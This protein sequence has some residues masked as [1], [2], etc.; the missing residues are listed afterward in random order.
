MLVSLVGRLDIYDQFFRG[1][2]C[3]PAASNFV[4]V[5]LA[6]MSRSRTT[7]TISAVLV[8]I[9][10]AAV[11]VLWLSLTV[12]RARIHNHDERQHDQNNIA[13]AMKAFM[14]FTMAGPATNLPLFRLAVPLSPRPR[15]SLSELASYE[16][17][18]GATDLVVW[19]S[20]RRAAGVPSPDR[21]QL[22]VR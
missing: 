9:G 20:G 11:V 4:A 6:T 5:L 13:A 18:S 16:Q 12:G 17:G 15:N 8:I 3:L 10:S 14:P 19:G 1:L 7:F 21:R 22:D 2:D